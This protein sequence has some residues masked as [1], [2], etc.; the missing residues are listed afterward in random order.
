MV[1]SPDVQRG[2]AHAAPTDT[3]QPLPR[4]GDLLAALG[5]LTVLPLRRPARESEA[6]GRATLF[7]PLVGLCVGALLVG[8]DRLLTNRAPGWLSAVVLVAVW[9]AV[10]GAGWL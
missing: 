2:K 5:L 3:Q 9:A 4:P 1:G 7:F 10:G 6:F 8:L